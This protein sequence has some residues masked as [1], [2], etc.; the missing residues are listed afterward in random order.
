M[1]R[2]SSR[3]VQQAPRRVELTRFNEEAP[4]IGDVTA[5]HADDDNGT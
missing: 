3:H 1:E 4:R 5:H 2:Q